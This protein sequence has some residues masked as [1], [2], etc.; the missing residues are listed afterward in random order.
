MILLPACCKNVAWI[1][2]NYSHVLVLGTA[3]W[4]SVPCLMMSVGYTKLISRIHGITCGL[5]SCLLLLSRKPICRSGICYLFSVLL[6]VT[7]HSLEHD[8]SH[9]VPCCWA[10]T[11]SRSLRRAWTK[12]VWH[13]NIGSHCSILKDEKFEQCSVS[14]FSLAWGA[15]VC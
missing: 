10:F 15:I 9:Q 5:N 14:T 4:F 6:S 8:T 7:G 2:I 3:K 1:I 13:D 11:R 12:T